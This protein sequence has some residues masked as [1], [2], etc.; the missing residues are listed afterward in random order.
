MEMQ[1]NIYL[2]IIILTIDN[3]RFMSFVGVQS[4]K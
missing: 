3:L 2:F 4:K 1:D